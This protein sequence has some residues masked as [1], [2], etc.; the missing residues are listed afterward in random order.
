MN[1]KEIIIIFSFYSI[2]Y[3]YSYFSFYGINIFEFATLTDLVNLFISEFIQFIVVWVIVFTFISVIIYFVYT[4]LRF[5]KIKIERNNIF[6][7]DESS[8][9]LKRKLKGFVFLSFLSVFILLLSFL[10]TYY[11]NKAVKYIVEIYVS[12]VL[13]TAFLADYFI[14][15][16][17][18]FLQI[19]FKISQNII[20]IYFFSLFIIPHFIILYSGFEIF[21]LNKYVESSFTYA[22]KNYVTGSN[23]T[24]IG[25]V[26]DKTFIY[27]KNKNET[28]FINNN[29]IRNFSRKQIILPGVKKETGTVVPEK[30]F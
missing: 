2:I 29:E 18:R 4:F 8:F 14:V 5:I 15:K 12:Y 17:K 13:L 10:M 28:L 27:D 23:Y 7:I 21:C 24:Y 6:E 20:R 9:R 30:G 1:F 11:Q 3:N 26:R 16:L 25:R 19:K 22:G